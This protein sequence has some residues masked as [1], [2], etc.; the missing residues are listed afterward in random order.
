MSGS[1]ATV[2]THRASVS[3]ACPTRF[4][5]PAL[6]AAQAPDSVPVTP[7]ELDRF[8]PERALAQ[9]VAMGDPQAADRFAR[10]LA[11]YVRRVTRTLLQDKSEAEDAAQSALL[12]I[13]ESARSYAGRGSLEGWAH[14]ITVR[15]ALRG[16]RKERKRRANEPLVDEVGELEGHQPRELY[17]IADA[18]PGELTD[19]LGRLPEVQRVALVLRYALGHT[20]PE[21]S[22][23]TESPIPTV[24]S[25]LLRG[26]GEIRKMIRRDLNIGRAPGRTTS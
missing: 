3:R 21:I 16:V 8:A 11:P 4:A 19:Y 2:A 7:P 24:K 26:Q 18:L 22:R 20:V 10:R 9:A 6:G 13:L 17:P 12:E 23:L 14:R 1:V 25:R 5:T 15:V